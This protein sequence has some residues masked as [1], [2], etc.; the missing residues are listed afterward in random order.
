NRA[1]ERR[2]ETY[3]RFPD[4]LP[5]GKNVRICSPVNPF[6]CVRFF[7]IDAGPSYSCHGG[8]VDCT[9]SS[10]TFPSLCNQLHLKSTAVV[11]TTVRCLTSHASPATASKS[12]PHKPCA[13]GYLT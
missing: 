7:P 6:K 2:P 8:L 1:E 12:Q 13:I 11:R 5:Q 4:D 10:S 9:H 3:A